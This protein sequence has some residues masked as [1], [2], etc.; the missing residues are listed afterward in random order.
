MATLDGVLNVIIPPIII[1]V[2]GYLIMKPLSEPFVR[3]Y[4]WIRSKFGHEEDNFHAVQT[5]YYE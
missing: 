5:I 2:F 3:L 4:S 1:I